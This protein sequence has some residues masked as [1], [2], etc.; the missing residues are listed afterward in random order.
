[1]LMGPGYQLLLEVVRRLLQRQCA[2][3][4]LPTVEQGQM[5]TPSRLCGRAACGRPCVWSTMCVVDRV[6]SIMCGRSGP[7]C[8][9][10][11]QTRPRPV[12]RALAGESRICAFLLWPLRVQ[13]TIDSHPKIGITMGWSA[14][15]EFRTSAWT[16]SIRRRDVLKFGVAGCGAATLG[17]AAPALA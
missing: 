6:G 13:R 7:G 16:S 10:S 14:M 9:S 3:P 4:S 15:G 1:M 12:Q 8:R 17:I 11:T 5:W 2:G